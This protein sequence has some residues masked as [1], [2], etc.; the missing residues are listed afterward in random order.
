MSY[1]YPRLSVWPPKTSK[2]TFKTKA[3]KYKVLCIRFHRT[4]DLIREFDT[5][6]TWHL[7]LRAVLF[8]CGTW[9]GRLS[10][11]FA[12]SWEKAWGRGREREGGKRRKRR[13]VPHAC[14]YSDPLETVR[15]TR[16]HHYDNSWTPKIRTSKV[17]RRP[18]EWEGDH[19]L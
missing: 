6:G 17:E 1:L 7:L 8:Y 9:C 3:A 2:R 18:I 5:T 16:E 13:R 4:K 14:Q 12:L 19:L 11:F 15:G 10:D